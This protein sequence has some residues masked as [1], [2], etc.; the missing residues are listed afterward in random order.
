MD[1]G[2]IPARTAIIPKEFQNR[3]GKIRVAKTAFL[4]ERLP[5]MFFAISFIPVDINWW[6]YSYE[7]VY[8]GYALGFDLL[9]DG[10]K[11]PEY[12]IYMDGDKDDFTV[13]KMERVNPIG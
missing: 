11:I 1:T 13:T 9:D 6:E 7:G 4:L 2:S 3:I 10:E 8:T 5:E 12:V